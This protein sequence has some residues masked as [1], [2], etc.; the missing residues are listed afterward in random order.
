MTRYLQRSDKSSK[1]L[2]IFEATDVPWF[3]SKSYEL[4]HMLSFFRQYVQDNFGIGPKYTQLASDWIGLD[5]VDKGWLELIY[6]L[7]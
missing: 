1:K 4:F 7:A 3:V 6:M 2:L 5:G